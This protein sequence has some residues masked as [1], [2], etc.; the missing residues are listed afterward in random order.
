MAGT[1]ASRRLTAREKAFFHF[2]FTQA[3]V[4]RIPDAA[5]Y[6]KRLRRVLERV[7]YV[8]YAAVRMRRWPV[9][10]T[11]LYGGAAT[12]ITIGHTIY[13]GSPDVYPAEGER[14]SLQAHELVHTCQVA[15]QGFG[16]PPWLATYVFAHFRDGGYLNNRFERE[17]FA[18]G[19]AV[20]E[21]LTRNPAAF[22]QVTAENVATG[23]VDELRQRL[24]QTLAAYGCRVTLW[25]EG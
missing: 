24:R 14:L 23:R 9:V 15:R 6:E 5:R 4:L 2:V 18:V 10:H 1:Q 12:A 25:P 8:N 11:A 16:T 7:V 17:A 20:Q 19:D 3:D 22:V 21:F 13:F